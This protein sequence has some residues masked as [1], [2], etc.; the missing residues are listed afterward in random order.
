MTIS[1]LRPHLNASKMMMRREHVKP[2]ISKV[3]P[4]S[5]SAAIS[6]RKPTVFA[7]GRRL[8]ARIVSRFATRGSPAYSRRP[9][10]TA[11]DEF[12]IPEPTFVI[13]M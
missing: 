8:V 1:G 10:A 13:Q 5:P 6:Y 7:S 3:A 11:C 2:D 9:Q 4:F 12:E